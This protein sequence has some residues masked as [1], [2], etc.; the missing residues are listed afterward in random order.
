MVASEF[1]P[2]NLGDWFPAQIV[3]WSKSEA[4]GHATTHVFRKTSL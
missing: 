1:N 3:A 4:K 2:V